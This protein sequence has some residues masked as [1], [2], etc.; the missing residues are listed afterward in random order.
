VFGEEDLVTIRAKEPLTFPTKGDRVAHFQYGAG[1]VTD[2]D[3]Y[4]TVIDFDGFGLRRFVTNRVV[5]DRTADPGPTAAER[6][7]AE[8]R[9]QREERAK[10]RAAAREA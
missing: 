3:V 10:K 4:H 2:L 9:R 1:T 6:R 8:L 7:T 5:L